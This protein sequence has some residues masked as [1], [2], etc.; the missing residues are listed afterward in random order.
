MQ[1]CS[2]LQEPQWHQDQPPNLS[3]GEDQSTELQDV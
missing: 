3:Q 2:D 1:Q